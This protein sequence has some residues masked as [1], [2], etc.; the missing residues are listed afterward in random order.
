MSQP[1]QEPKPQP[2]TISL[3][4]SGLTLFQG[5]ES[6]GKLFATI[7]NLNGK[8]EGFRD[9]TMTSLSKARMSISPLERD[10]RNLRFSHRKSEVS[11][12]SQSHTL[13]PEKRRKTF[14]IYS[15]MDNA[16]WDLTVANFFLPISRMVR[17]CLIPLL[18]YL[19]EELDMRTDYIAYLEERAKLIRNTRV[20]RAALMTG[21][22]SDLQPP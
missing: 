5:T 3:A 18:F 17:L 12:G 10:N 1:I 8:N 14:L 13:F 22:S 19:S 20:R 2:L 9:S 21:A 4:S 15:P 7:V 6:D 16:P 11:F